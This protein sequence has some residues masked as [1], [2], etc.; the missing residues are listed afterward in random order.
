MRLSIHHK[1]SSFFFK[2]MIL[3]TSTIQT[4]EQLILVI[5]TS[6]VH[7]SAQSI[8]SEQ[9][10]VNQHRFSSNHLGSHSQRIAFLEAFVT[11]SGENLSSFLIDASWPVLFPTVFGS[12]SALSIVPVI[13]EFTFNTFI[14][15]GHSK[16]FMG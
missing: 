11:V 3:I 13:S 16:A 8:T 9:T 2:V 14:L 5:S 12:L 15:M 4:R 7:F 10:S 1:A 6:F